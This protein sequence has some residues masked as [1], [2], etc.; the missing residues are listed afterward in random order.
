MNF[1]A[2]TQLRSNAASPHSPQHM[3]VP[4]NEKGGYL[5]HL[6]RWMPRTEHNQPIILVQIYPDKLDSDHGFHHGQVGM[7][8]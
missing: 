6:A 8:V 4:L 5:A 1:F 2:M 3:P 7:V